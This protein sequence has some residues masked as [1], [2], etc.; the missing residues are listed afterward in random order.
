MIIIILVT[1][2]KYIKTKIIE[3]DHMLVLKFSTKFIITKTQWIITLD[4]N[5]RHNVMHWQRNLQ[6][7]DR[8]K[9][10]MAFIL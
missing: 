6:Y 3:D 1:I 10:F 4:S 8:L 7:I 2:Q 9:L 5:A